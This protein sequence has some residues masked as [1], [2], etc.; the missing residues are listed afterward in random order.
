MMLT[1]GRW[2][3]MIQCSPTALASWAILAMGIS[4]LPAVM[5]R[6]ANSSIPQHDIRQVTHALPFGLSFFRMNLALYSLMFR[7][8]AFRSS[9][10]SCIPSQWLGVQGID[11]LAGICWMMALPHQAL[12]GVFVDN[13][14]SI[15][16]DPPSN[17]NC[18]GCFSTTQGDED[19]V[20]VHRSCPVAPAMSRWGIRASRRYSSLDGL[21]SRAAGP[22]W[23]AGISLTRS[24]NVH[25]HHP[26]IHIGHFDTDGFPC[27]VSGR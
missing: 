26:L 6:S 25:A 19:A 24:V 7:T 21:N 9:Q 2:V 17:F 5:I 23:P 20:G 12:V 14:N 16:G 27:P 15:F 3:A 10:V 8:W 18:D 13:T 11:H 1:L 4:S 22:S